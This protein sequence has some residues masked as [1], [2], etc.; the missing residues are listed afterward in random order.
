MRSVADEAGHALNELGVQVGDVRVEMIGV[1]YD[2]SPN[3]CDAHEG[4]VC[5]E[6]ENVVSS[7]SVQWLQSTFKN[8]LLT[9]K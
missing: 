4:V 1:A 2:D 9:A 8:H 7:H 6:E 5:S 3:V